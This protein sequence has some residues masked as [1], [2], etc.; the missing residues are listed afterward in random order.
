MRSFR[1]LSTH[2][3]FALAGAAPRNV[4]GDKLRFRNLRRVTRKPDEPPSAASQRREECLC[5]VVQRGPLSF[6]G[7]LQRHPAHPNEIKARSAA[8][9]SQLGVQTG[10]ST[11]RALRGTGAGSGSVR[12]LCSRFLASGAGGTCRTSASCFKGSGAG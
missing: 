6:R 3:S 11:C 1:A 2:K 9:C 8:S 7:L 4:L 5:Q 12:R 10:F